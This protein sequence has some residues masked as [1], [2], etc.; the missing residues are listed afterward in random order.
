MKNAI[1][2][3]VALFL[4]APWVYGQ[5][6]S[7]SG[8]L[9][10]RLRNTGPIVHEGQV[11]GYYYFYNLERKDSKNNNY[12]LSVYDENLREI[13]SINIIRPTSYA[14]LDGAFNGNAFAFFFYDVR[15]HT[16]ELISYDET[17]KQIGAT[18]KK[19]SSKLARA[20]FNA[21]AAS[22]GEAS[23]P[24][25]VPITSKGF[26]FYGIKE[27]KK[28]H[29]EIEFYDSFL[30]RVWT[31]RAGENAL[32]VEMASEGF[33][34]I[35]YA[36]SLLIKKKSTNAKTMITELMVHRIDDGKVLFRTPM[37][38][39]NYNISFGNVFFDKE[40]QTF[41]MFGE[42]FDKKD[43][44]MTSQSLGFV[45][46]T[47]DMSGKIIGE[48][49]NSWAN[50]ISRV[51]PV[52]EKG[53]F[54]GTKASILFHDFVRTSDG[55]IFAVGELYKKTASAAG[56]AT[57]ILSIAAGAA[58]GYYSGGGAASTQLNIYDMVI[59]QF[60]PDYSISKVHIFPKDKNV[61]M[62]PAGYGWLNTKMLSYYAKTVG[63]FDFSFSQVSSDK[64]T[65]TVAYINYDREQ[66][67]KSKNVL[68]T[69]V[70][71]PEKTFSIDKMDLNRKSTDYYVYRGKDGYIL[72]TEYFKKEKRVNSRLEKI[73]F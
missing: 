63:G 16:A 43:D 36:G 73:N 23:Q 5:N 40:H 11:K 38:T 37:S 46:L 56:I 42:Y 35:D 24:F 31:E 33:Q 26:L 62:L 66:G 18:I 47:L 13:N 21:Y 53:K 27:G 68:G 29:Y 58:T 48:K 39:S 10:M 65:F 9:R 64:E 22:G 28:N 8:V 61:V 1:T 70:Y 55:Q 71:T 7:K 6:L 34:S 60:N 50:E 3:I 44:A 54:E 41:V 25:L 57:Q 72:V 2:L 67:E 52:N 69:I 12:Q 49:L 4:S 19:V 32:A 45:Y 17:L 14:L 15:S 30:K 20:S 59:F 51:T